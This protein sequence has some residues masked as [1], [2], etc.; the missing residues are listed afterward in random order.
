MING[1]LLDALSSIIEQKEIPFD[2]YE[3]LNDY[4]QQIFAPEITT[5]DIEQSHLDGENDL[6][7]IFNKTLPSDYADCSN[8]LKYSKNVCCMME[9]SWAKYVILQL[10]TAGHATKIAQPPIATSKTLFYV[11]SYDSPYSVKFLEI[12][13]RVKETSLMH[14]ESLINER[15]VYYF[16]VTSE[17]KM[18]DGI[19]VFH[20]IFVLCFGLSISTIAFTIEL[21]KF[22]FGRKISKYIRKRYE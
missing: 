13:R 8:R 18:G 14:W 9:E 20:F 6:K 22:K 12:M 16:G 11:F 2:K 10:L 3:D 17:V 15:Y 19:K 5:F 4:C 21:I 1:L 7:R